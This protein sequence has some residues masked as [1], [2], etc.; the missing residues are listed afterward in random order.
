MTRRGRPHF[1]W[2]VIVLCAGAVGV[3]L[4][5]L[6][7]T[8][9]LPLQLHP[10]EWVIITGAL[11]LAQRNSFE[12]SLFLRPDHVEIQ[13]S[14]LAYQAYAYLVV[15]APV[16]V[17]YAA[18]PAA[19]LLISRAITALFGIAMVVLAY[20]IGRR[21]NRSI[22]VIAVVLFAIFPPFI[23]HSHFATPDVPLASVLMV[24]ILATMF[25]LENPAYASL[26]VAS[27]AT[28]VAIAIKYPGVIATVLIALVVIFAGLRDRAFLRIL[29][30]GVT[31]IVAV[32]VF[33]FLISPVL[34]TNFQGVRDALQQESRTT[35][36]GADG[37]GWGGNLVFY[38]DQYL[39]AGG[40]LLSVAVVLGVIA[41]IRLRLVLMLPVL[42]GSVF[43]VILSAVPLHWERWGVPM[44]VTPLIL[45]SAGLYYSYRFIAGQASWAKWRKPL[46]V[47]VSAVV[48][49]NLLVSSI[50]VVGVLL[51]Q[52]TRVTSQS[53]F[54]DRGLTSENTIFEGYTPFLPGNSQTIFDDFETVDGR[55]VAVEEARRFVVTSSCMSDRFLRD[56]QYVDER[57]FYAQL[58]AELELELV[59]DA[60][61]GQPQ[62][63]ALEVLNIIRAG[64]AVRNLVQDGRSGCTLRVYRLADPA[65]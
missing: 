50:V 13:L 8:W 14:Y 32:L 1:N 17:A 48:V 45:G 29:T 35:H 42:L 16:E 26:L 20:F 63:S 23:Q 18:H 40:I 4:R 24:V 38:A 33:L 62:P 58:E 36:A 43:W 19:F 10:D 64:S 28:S 37:L 25:Y 7:L 9:G 52:D 6:G 59:V 51:A 44:Y 3:A 46:A 54:V 55:L 31:A 41:A 11:D 5:I 65:P 57:K 27:G 47:T 53:Q 12:P 49:T 21:F 39:L 15:H 2:V 61:G 30:H 34:F 22:A 60:S 56:P